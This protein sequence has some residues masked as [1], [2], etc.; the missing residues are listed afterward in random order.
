MYI[1]KYIYVFYKQ[2]QYTCMFCFLKSTS[3]KLH[4]LNKDGNSIII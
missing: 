2:E 4:N 1:F 3:E